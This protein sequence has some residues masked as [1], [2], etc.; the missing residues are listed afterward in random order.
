MPLTTSHT[1]ARHPGPVASRL[2]AVAAVAVMLVALTPASVAVASEVVDAAPVATLQPTI[3][4][5]EA[6]AHAGDKTRFTPGDR[7]S[8]PF[9]PRQ[10]D[11]W[12]VGGVDPRELPAGRLQRALAARRGATRSAAARGT[13]AS[14][15][16]RHRGGR[17]PVRG[18]RRC[19]VRPAGRRGRSGRAQARGLR[20]PPVLGADRQLDPTRLGEAVHDRLLRGRRGR[21]GRSPANEQRRVDDGRLERLDELEDDERHRT[22]PTPAARGSS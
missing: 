7:V 10:S 16:R 20:L 4:Y 22:R 17:R 5:E 6:V 11:R 19:A 13:R 3:Q 18:P 15:R 9:K 2:V 14:G 21:Q 8:V 12:A 1:S